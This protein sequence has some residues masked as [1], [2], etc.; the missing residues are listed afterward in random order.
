M[1][2][3]QSGSFAN[4][5]LPFKLTSDDVL[6]A[7][8]IGLTNSNWNFD[9]FPELG[10]DLGEILYYSQNS[11]IGALSSIYNAFQFRMNQVTKGSEHTELLFSEYEL[12]DKWVDLIALPQ[13]IDYILNTEE[14]QGFRNVLVKDVRD[15][16]NR[17]GK[18]TL[19]EILYY[20]SYNA[21]ERNKISFS[22]N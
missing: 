3:A 1:K 4:Q 6:N 11:R 15:V 14:Y 13:V 22:N 10:S 17:V 20:A 2:A 19:P 9:L 5:K 18:R 7:G 16:T 12:G 8:L 21:M